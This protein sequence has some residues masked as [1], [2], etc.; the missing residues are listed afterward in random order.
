M[1]D[2]CTLGLNVTV[3]TVFLDGERVIGRVDLSFIFCIFISNMK[4]TKHLSVV[5]D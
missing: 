2:I 3:F 5:T 1:I 4:F